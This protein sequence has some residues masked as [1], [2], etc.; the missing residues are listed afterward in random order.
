MVEGGAKRL[1]ASMRSVGV[2]L[3]VGLL[4]GCGGTKLD[5]LDEPALDWGAQ[6]GEWV[7]INYWAVWCTPCR[8]EIPELN[9]FEEGR[10]LGVNYDN[11]DLTTLRQQT[12]DMGIEFTQ[13]VAD[14]AQLLGYDRPN[15]LPATF[16]FDPDGVYRGVMVGPQTHESLSAWLQPGVEVTQ[17]HPLNQQGLN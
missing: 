1:S 16:V 2:I 17:A 6:R 10:V 9:R 13:L 7:F 4:A 15:V 5:T 8:K 3:L 14:P 12:R 11:P